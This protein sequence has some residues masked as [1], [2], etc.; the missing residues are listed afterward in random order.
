MKKKIF[1]SCI[2]ISILLIFTSCSNLNTS[3][4]PT[5][6]VWTDFASYSDFQTTFNA[7]MNDGYYIRYEFTSDQWAQISSSTTSEGRHSWT[8]EK[9]KDWLIGRGFGETESTKEVAWLTTID[10]GFIASRTGN[11]VYFILK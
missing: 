9:I 5:Y 7:T 11:T 1:F 2:F 10:H 8:K 4:E 6:T 3:K